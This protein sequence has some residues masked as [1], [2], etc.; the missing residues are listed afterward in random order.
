MFVCM[1]TTLESVQGGW[2]VPLFSSLNI[3]WPFCL[4][5]CFI[6]FSLSK[7]CPLKKI[8]RSKQE[9]NDLVS[10]SKLLAFSPA[11]TQNRIWKKCFQNPDRPIKRRSER[12]CLLLSYLSFETVF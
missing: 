2:G 4:A 3:Q 9:N 7:S 12:I 10:L 1:C 8:T 6:F 11:D 5:S